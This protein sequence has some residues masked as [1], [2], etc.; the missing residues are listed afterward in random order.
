MPPRVKNLSN[1]RN[2]QL[3]SREAGL[4][5]YDTALL[6]NAAG[7]VTEAPSACVFL[8]RDGVVSTPDLASGILE[9]ITRDAVI[10]LCRDELGLAVQER[11]VD[12]TELYLADEVFLTG[13]AVEI[14]PLVAVDR[15]PIGAGVSGP[16]ATRLGRLLHD[17]ARG[18]VPQYARWVTRVDRPRARAT[19]APGGDGRV[20]CCRARGGRRRNGKGRHRAMIDR[21]TLDL[22]L[23]EH[24]RRVARAERYGAEPGAGS[25]R[26]PWRASVAGR[27][28]ALARRL[29]PASAPRAGTSPQCRRIAN[30]SLARIVGQRVVR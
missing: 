3:A 23:A 11:A 15:L 30:V 29:D 2:S 21:A 25:R 24:E 6:L 19:E 26:G 27:C 5:G 10:T 4:N 16:V 14:Q 22:R 18:G 12:R 28:V 20:G 1:Y 13:N 8:V 17:I 7:R 9:S